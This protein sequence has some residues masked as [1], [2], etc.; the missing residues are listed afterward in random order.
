[1]DGNSHPK[2]NLSIHALNCPRNV[3][4]IFMHLTRWLSIQAT[5]MSS[6]CFLN[7]L[8]VYRMR[9]VERAKRFFLKSLGMQYN[10][11][12]GFLSKFSVKY[13]L[14]IEILWRQE[15]CIIIS[16]PLS[17]CLIH[18][19]Y[20]LLN[21]PNHSIPNVIFRHHLSSFLKRQ[22]FRMSSAQGF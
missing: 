1:M 16:K 11:D 7:K 17:Q 6:N 9:F 10:K 22:L 13:S 14:Q 15:A 2:A 4:E 8:C 3:V 18:F 12:I 20:R 19:N 5:F 21:I